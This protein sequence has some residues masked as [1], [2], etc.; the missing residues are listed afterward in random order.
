MLVI[1]RAQM[2]AIQQARDG[3]LAEWV[4]QYLRARHPRTLVGLD[5]PEATR[6][7]LVGISR[8]RR[9]GFA[10]S[11][12]YGEFVA[13]MLRHTPDFDTHPE[14]TSRFSPHEG[15]TADAALSRAL[16]Q[17]TPAAWQ[18]VALAAPPGAWGA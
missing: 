2:E 18:V 1:R 15:E 6:R 17:M 4:V 8:A 3:K 5:E 7:A 9:H 14:F 12:A 13:A 11:N 10:T 16:R